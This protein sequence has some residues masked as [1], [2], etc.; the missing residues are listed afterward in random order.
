MADL[1]SSISSASGSTTQLDQLVN[2]YKTSQQSKIDKLNSHQSLLEN[3]RTFFNSLN[4]KINSL[5]STIDTFRADTASDS[6]T[7]RNISSTENT[8]LTATSTGSAEL[9]TIAARVERLAT[10]DVLISDRKKLADLLDEPAGTKSFDL[11]I[12][13][14]KKSIS[15]VFDGTETTEQGMKKIVQAVNSAFAKTSN[16]D[17]DIGVN[18]SLVKDSSTTGRLTLTSKNT[19]GDN[20][21]LFSDA[22][23]L[24]KIGLDSNKLKSNSEK[25]DTATD[26]SAGYKS[27]S[28]SNLDSKIL[29]N[30]IEITR[31]TNTITDA[32]DGVT[33][34]LLKAQTTDDNSEIT[35]ENTVDLDGVKSFID[36][37]LKNFNDI[38]SF[39]NQ[40]PTLR[41]Q[42]ASISNLF[43]NLRNLGAANLN[44]T[45]LGSDP[46]YLSE[47]GIT[48]D[49]AGSLSVSDSDK[50]LKL[51][52]SDPKKVSD[53]FIGKGGLVDKL[54]EAIKPFQGESGLI[55]SRTSSLNSQIDQT[56]KRTTEVTARIDAQAEGLRKQYTSYL[57][58]LY[59][60][61]SQSSLL[62][63]IGS[64]AN[65]SGYNSLIT[66][67]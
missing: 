6:F 26:N 14:S 52:K 60:A 53:L 47:L 44:F 1:S 19:G 62:G 35:L 10:K 51:L 54:D 32:M 49:S 46:K 34:N 21:I 50:L 5:N 57:K 22:S 36:P 63:F 27:T 23:F 4:G 37:L 15:I 18:A 65:T 31:G 3:T 28:Y 41:R 30:S 39:I 25:R 43:S 55:K 7:K 56:Q 11:T 38:L 40:N 20:R 29:V 58:L 8:F 42:D 66:S 61:Q 13:S 64:G 45:G 59:Q 17:A 9:G 67:G 12:G 24:H 16:S 48:V 33:F 2:S